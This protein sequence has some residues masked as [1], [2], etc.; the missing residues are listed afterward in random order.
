MLHRNLNYIDI[1]NE[2]IKLLEISSLRVTECLRLRVFKQLP[3][4]PVDEVLR[5]EGFL[6]QLV[7]EQDD[8]VH[9]TEPPPGEGRGLF[10]Q[11]VKGGCLVRW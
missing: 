10:S 3:V 11:L 6:S 7:T 4:W 1:Y 9:A 5:H 8:V 2:R